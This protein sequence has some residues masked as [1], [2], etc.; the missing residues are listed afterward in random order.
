MT[1]GFVTHGQGGAHFRFPN[2]MRAGGAGYLIE[3]SGQ[4]TIVSRIVTKQNTGSSATNS[5]NVPNLPPNAVGKG[6]ANRPVFETST[7]TTGSASLASDNGFSTWLLFGKRSG[8]NLQI[9]YTRSV[10]YD[11]NTLFFGV[12]FNIRKSVGGL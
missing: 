12:G 10:E 4:Q 8:L 1:S 9:G 7:V 11:L 2:W 5:A 6:L 3:P